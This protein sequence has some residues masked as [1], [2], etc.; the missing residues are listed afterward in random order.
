MVSERCF[1]LLL[2]G[3]DMEVVPTNKGGGLLNGRR[4]TVSRHGVLPFIA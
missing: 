1:Q 3:D 2:I 4:E